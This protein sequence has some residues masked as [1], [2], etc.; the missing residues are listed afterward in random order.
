MAGIGKVYDLGGRLGNQPA[1]W[2][3]AG[4]GEGVAIALR[5]C[6][7]RL[8]GWPTAEVARFFSNCG[9]GSVWALSIV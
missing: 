6:R 3:L 4:D 8:L 7:L 5:R 2:W 1:G 9:G